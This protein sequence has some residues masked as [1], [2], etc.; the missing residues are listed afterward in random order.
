MNIELTKEQY[1]ELLLLVLLGS[2]VRGGVADMRGEYGKE[3]DEL[4]EYL[5]R[6]AKKF[7]CSDLAEYFEGHIVP[8][9]RLA[10]EYEKIIEEYNDDEFWSQLSTRLGQ[11]DFEKTISKEEKQHMKDNNGRFP[12]RIHTL[13]EEYDK[14]FEKHGIDRLEIKEN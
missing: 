3:M 11:R 14:E 2:W 8:S 9:D 12:E 5:L 1:K 6:E 4:E 10:K 13:Y 7:N